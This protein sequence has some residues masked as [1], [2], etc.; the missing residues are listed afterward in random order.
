[1]LHLPLARLSE[2]SIKGVYIVNSVNSENVYWKNYQN[3]YTINFSDPVDKDR[4]DRMVTLV[5]QMLEIR[6]WPSG[7]RQIREE[8]IQSSSSA[9]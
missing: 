5:T 2:T 1:M 3:L 7:Q 9:L 8:L 6:F 4:Y